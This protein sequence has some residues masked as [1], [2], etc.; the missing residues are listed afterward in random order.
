MH[1]PPNDRERHRDFLNQYYGWSRNLYDVTRRYYLFGRDEVL[2]RLARESWS[3]LVEVGP[4]TG[5]NLAILHGAKPGARFG[6][7]DASDAMLEV[8]RKRCAFASFVQGFAEDV[9]YGSILGRRPERILFSYCLSM[10]QDPAAALR[11]AVRQLAPGG[12][13]VVVDF[14]DGL[15]LPSAVRGLLHRWLREFHVEP[16]STDLFARRD[17]TLRFGPGRYWLSASLGARSA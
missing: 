14:A 2:G 8:A 9:D 6:G 15:E 7:V 16:L 11:N 17:A 3:D 12:R 5:R 4:G 13:V 10:V 1:A